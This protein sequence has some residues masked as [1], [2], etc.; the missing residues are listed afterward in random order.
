MN[1]PNSAPRGEKYP[2]MNRAHTLPEWYNYRC[3]YWIGGGMCQGKATH[4]VEGERGVGMTLMLPRCD[5]HLVFME[6]LPDP[7]KIPIPDKCRM[8]EDPIEEYDYKE[9]SG[10]CRE[11]YIEEHGPEIQE[12]DSSDSWAGGFAENH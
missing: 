7:A 10:L 8:C 11:C 12:P 1:T 4:M 5:K 3:N 6:Y 2:L 9:Y